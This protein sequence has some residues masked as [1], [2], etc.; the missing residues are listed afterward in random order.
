MF[1]YRYCFT[2]V[3]V[4]WPGSVH[5]ARIFAYSAINK[6]LRQERIP[7]C[8]KVIVE[9]EDPVPICILWDPAYPLLPFLMKEFPVG[10]NTAAEQ[11]FGYRL[12]STRMVIECLLNEI[13]SGVCRTSQDVGVF[14]AMASPRLIS[15]YV[16]VSKSQQ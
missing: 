10:G 9:D 15:F 13:L 4:K 2:D 3:V 12:S 7:R 16:F 1:D 5:D 8:M 11:L 14:V 6:C